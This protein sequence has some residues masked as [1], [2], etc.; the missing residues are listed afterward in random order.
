MTGIWG[1]F[2][3]FIFFF[4]PAL[5]VVG[6]FVLK[7]RNARLGRVIE[8]FDRDEEDPSPPPT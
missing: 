5:L 6:W 7:W 4:C 3:D 1:W 8:T 2:G